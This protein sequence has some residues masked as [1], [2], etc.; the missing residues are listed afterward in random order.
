MGK[1]STKLGRPTQT[2]SAVDNEDDRAAG[3]RPALVMGEMVTRARER[4]KENDEGNKT[5]AWKGKR[6]LERKNEG[7]G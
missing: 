1:A 6:M 4:D 7:G 3:T 5:E 2:K